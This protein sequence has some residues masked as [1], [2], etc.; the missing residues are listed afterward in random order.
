MDHTMGN[1]LKPD[2]VV[3]PEDH[4]RLSILASDALERF[5][6]AAQELLVE[7]DRAKVVPADELPSNV[8]RMGSGVEFQSD[9]GKTRKVRLVFPGEAD[10]DAGKVSILTPIGAALIGLAEGQS[11]TWTTRDGTSRELTIL[12]VESATAVAAA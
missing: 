1:R 12:A 3:T 9:D 11:I 10:I 2:I 7:L 4:N 8:I 6:D 5:P